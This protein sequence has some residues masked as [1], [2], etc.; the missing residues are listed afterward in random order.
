VRIKS[1]ASTVPHYERQIGKVEL[2][3]AKG[4]VRWTRG[5]DG[6]SI[7]VPNDPPCHHAYAFKIL[8]A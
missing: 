7:R 8:P 6:L 5:P 4:E 3:G 2:L 1:L